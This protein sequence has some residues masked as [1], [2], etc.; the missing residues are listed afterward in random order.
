MTISR[1]A[2]VG[3][4]GTLHTPALPGLALQQGQ[5]MQHVP[6]GGTALARCGG[7][8]QL[9]AVPLL[10]PDTEHRKEHLSFVP[11]GV[12]PVIITFLCKWGHSL[13]PK[14]PCT[15]KDGAA[16]VSTWAQTGEFQI[17]Q[18]LK[19]KL[20]PVAVGKEGWAALSLCLSPQ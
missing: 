10:F 15:A 16:T 13:L 1:K 9:V 3:T 5:G 4:Q 19:Q 17:R 18:R 11:S 20:D 7:P 2:V 12:S 8:F 14:I 6:C